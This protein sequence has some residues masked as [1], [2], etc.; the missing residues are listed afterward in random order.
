TDDRTNDRDAERNDDHRREEDLHDLEHAR[1][2]VLRSDLK[3]GEWNELYG[4]DARSGRVSSAL[5][6]S[7]SSFV[8]KR[9]PSAIRSTSMAMESMACS[10]RSRRFVRSCGRRGSL[11]PRSIRRAY[12]LAI[13]TKMTV[14]AMHT[15]SVTG[16]IMTL[17]GIVASPSPSFRGTA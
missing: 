1:R 17:N 15:N 14:V 11:A 2:D 8:V 12:A 9:W 16:M 5:A 13:G 10:I 3:Q 7:A 4:H 6:R